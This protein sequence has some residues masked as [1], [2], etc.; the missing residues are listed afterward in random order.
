MNYRHDFVSGYLSLLDFEKKGKEDFF[1]GIKQSDD[2][3]YVYS[4]KVDPT[5]KEN[6]FYLKKLVLILLWMIGGYQVIFSGNKEV[7][8]SFAAFA[9]S[10]PELQTT[11]SSM[12]N[13]FH[14][15][16][17]ILYTKEKPT[18][19]N[20]LIELKSDFKGCRIGF[21]AGGSDR[22]V[23]AVIDGKVVYSQETLWNPKEQT[24]WKYHWDGILDS[25]KEAS[26]HLP[27]IDSIG[28]STAGIVLQGEIAQSNLFMKVPLSDQEIHCRSIFQDIGKQY[29]P[30]VPVFVANDGDVSAYGGAFAFQKDNILGLSLGTSLAAGYCQ[31]HSFLGYITEFGK[32]PFD[33][34]SKAP[35]HYATGIQ[36]AGAMLLSQNGILSLGSLAGYAFSGVKA[37]Q[38]LSL[39]KEADSGNKEVLKAY[40]DL[41][42]YLGH[43]LALYH[44]FMKIDHVLLFGR[45]MTGKGGERI[46]S[47][48]KETLSS[49]HLGIELLIPDENFRRLGQSYMA[50]GLV[51]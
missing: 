34:S 30:S 26:L 39:Q 19:K 49:L 28:V 1:I 42:E 21:D 23:S 35:C 33:F 43:A 31:N 47:K 40:E 37:E 17:E 50:A 18:P 51:E 6:C 12:G 44:K 8:E 16:A 5:N 46:V 22:K 38:L 45:V 24:S 4:T 9:Q 27:H 2:L 41:G 15:K 32:V 11:L 3:L 48:A 10:D 13:I 36:G 7:Y 14:R 29:F 20:R 25:L